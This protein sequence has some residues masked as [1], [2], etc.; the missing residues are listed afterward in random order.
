MARSHEGKIGF[1]G[2][3]AGINLCPVNQY[4][5]HYFWVCRSMCMQKRRVQLDLHLLVCLAG[6]WCTKK[7]QWHKKPHA[8]FWGRNETGIQSKLDSYIS[9]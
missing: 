8:S 1:R 2:G 6:L 4:I 7:K 3:L 5:T 9:N